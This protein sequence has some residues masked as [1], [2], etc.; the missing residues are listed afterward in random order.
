MRMKSI[1]LLFAATAI[2]FFF[3][4]GDYDRADSNLQTFYQQML[5]ADFAGARHS[6]DDA[7]R[8]WPGNARYYAWSAYCAS[9]KL[10]SQCPRCLRGTDSAM[11]GA[12][13]QA[14]R[15]AMEDYRRALQL[16]NRDAVAYHNMAWLEHILGDDSVAEGDWRQA[17]EI[18][19][20]NAAFHLSYGMF[21]EESEKTQEGRA[22]F[23]DAIELS[24]S[25][26]DSPFF[27]RYRKH[28]PDQ[29]DA[30]V[31]HCIS[32]IE[33]RLGRARDPILEARLGK[34][35]QYAGDRV[36][37]SQL[38]KDAVDQLPNLPLVW[39]N[40]GENYEASG[41]LVQAMDCYNKAHTID[42]SLAGS[43]LRI[44]E[45]YLQQGQKNL[46]ATNFQLAAQRWERVNPI[47]A[48]HNNR[49]YSGPRQLIDDLLPTTLV[50]YV[51]PCEASQAYGALAELYPSNPELARRS[52]TCEELPAP[53]LCNETR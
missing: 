6:I 17:T 45:L 46:A 49:L 12:D 22:Q 19:P 41:D 25:I 13:Q 15:A 24:P 50:W 9:Q 34:L 39:L 26:L 32:K 31:A 11:N 52:R 30:I 36:R 16:N 27:E 29:A 35:Y 10:P 18:D 8:L 47:T 28:F 2:I 14:A 21:L 53:H 3:V 20:D 7:I 43:Y 51:S 4:V 37:S 42:P 40:L 33:S 44:G 38:L 5:K 1:A 23:E 48:S